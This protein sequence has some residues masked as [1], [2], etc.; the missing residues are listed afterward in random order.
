MASPAVSPLLIDYIAADNDD[1]D[2][3]MK[4]NEQPPT[5]LYR[6]RRARNKWR[7]ETRHVQYR[8]DFAHFNAIS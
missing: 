2:E 4:Y 6:R 3:T 7:V 1:D 5:L 8:S